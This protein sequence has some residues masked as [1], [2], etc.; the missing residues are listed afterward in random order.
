MNSLIFNKDFK[1][2]LQENKTEVINKL[3]LLVDFGNKLEYMPISN[4]HLSIGRFFGSMIN[5]IDIYITNNIKNII[6]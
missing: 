2:S 1:H 6:M 5:E 4:R 3:K